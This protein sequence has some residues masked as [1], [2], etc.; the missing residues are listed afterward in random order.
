M[1]SAFG[2]LGSAHTNVQSGIAVRLPHAVQ[3]R[4]ALESG[5]MA[6]EDQA[7]KTVTDAAHELIYPQD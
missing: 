7:D 1:D 2:L 3:V 4:L 6:P 5:I